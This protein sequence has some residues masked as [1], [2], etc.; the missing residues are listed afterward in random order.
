MQSIP[1]YIRN[2][3]PHPLRNLSNSRGFT[4]PSRS[5]LR[6][7]RLDHMTAYS[8]FG[9]PHPHRVYRPLVNDQLDDAFLSLTSFRL[10]LLENGDPFI[11]TGTNLLPHKPHRPEACLR[12]PTILALGPEG[13]VEETFLSWGW[14]SELIIY[15]ATGWR[16]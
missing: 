1:Y 9:R 7:G 3:P 10:P 11:L 4:G 15:I 6:V 8:S 16:K 13:R 12:Q 14:I 2:M 5:S